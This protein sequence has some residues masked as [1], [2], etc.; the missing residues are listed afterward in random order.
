MGEAFLFDFC[1]KDPFGL[2]KDIFY[3][4]FSF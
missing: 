4:L 1:K 3:L 2:L